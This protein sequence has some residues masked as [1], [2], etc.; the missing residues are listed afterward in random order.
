MK[1][2]QFN[3]V[4]SQSNIHWVGRKVTG[5]HDGTIAIKQGNLTLEDG[6]LTGGSFVIDTTSIKILDV[7]DPATNAQFAGHLASDDFFAIDRYPEAT[8]EI[9]RVDNDQ[10]EGNLTIKGISQPVS[11]KASV[12]VAND[13]LTASGKIVVDRTRYGIRFRS[14]NFFKDLGDTL[15]YNDFDLNV[16]ITARALATPSLA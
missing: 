7:T 1:K 12:S 13:T 8:F 11:F 2:Q 15:I 3:I 16:S 4:V 10:V 9:S 5:A 6:K 14:G